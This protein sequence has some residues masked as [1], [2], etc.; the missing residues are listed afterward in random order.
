MTPED[1]YK[2]SF[3]GYRQ[4]P[5]PGV[6]KGVNRRLA[7]RDFFTPG[8]KHFNILYVAAAAVAVVAVLWS[9]PDTEQAPNAVNQNITASDSATDV[10]INTNGIQAPDYNENRTKNYTVT[11]P[12]KIGNETYESE[13]KVDTFANDITPSDINADTG[14]AATSSEPEI[15]CSTFTQQPMPSFTSAFHASEHSGCA[16]LT[17]YLHNLSQ[18]TEYSQWNLG[19][20]E[21]SYEQDLCVT[22]D[23]PGT[24]IIALRTVCGTYAKTSYDTIQVSARRQAGIAVAIS[25]MTITAEARNTGD[26]S[27]V[28][29]FGDYTQQSGKRRTHTYQQ[30]GVYDITLIVSDN[31]CSDTIR[32]SVTIKQPEFSLTFPNAIVASRSGAT[33][34]NYK[35]ASPENKALFGPKGNVDEVSE[36]SLIIYTRS[37]KQIFATSNPRDTWNG[38]YLNE[39][40]PRGVYVYKCRCKF[41][42]G[43]TSSVNGNITLL[44][45]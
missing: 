28:W 35:S 18:N 33:T 15:Q 14:V 38:Y 26:A 10:N 44:W 21:T 23:K 17:V 1:L 45:E 29:D 8:L 27:I 36:Y 7:T 9:S 2:N 43:E 12:K 40:L 11:T 20:G 34:G 39:L 6:W 5:P 37:G 30:P 3:D 22:Y 24:Y 32:K 19:N 4:D 42:N 41:I 25:G 16:P 13:P 31:I